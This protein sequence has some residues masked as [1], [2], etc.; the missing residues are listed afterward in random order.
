M[1]QI[2]KATS[3]IDEGLI[4]IVLNIILDV[5]VILLIC[6]LLATVFMW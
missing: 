1:Q 4:H 3:S 5:C 6:Y 2:I